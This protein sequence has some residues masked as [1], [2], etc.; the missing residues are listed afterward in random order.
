MTSRIESSATETQQHTARSGRNRLARLVDKV[1]LVRVL[2]AHDGLSARVAQMAGYDAVWA[3]GLGVSASHGLPDR[4]GITISEMARITMVMRRAS[5][6][7]I[8]VD[9]DAGFADPY[10]MQRMVLE[11]AEAGATAVCIED[12]Q[13]PKVNSFRPGNRLLAPEEFAERIK[14]ATD[15]DR[16]GLAIIARIESFIA[17]E[18]LDAAINRAQIYAKAGADALLI[19]SKSDKPREVMEFCRLA[20]QEGIDLPLCVV[21]TTYPSATA[22]ELAATGVDL[23]V[24]ANQALRAALSAMLDVAR[25]IRATDRSATIEDRVAS[26]ADVFTATEPLSR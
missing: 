5:G 10:L 19:H 11:Y 20:R 12:K 1:G 6:M 9:G 21:P 14:I 15:T 22:S 24:F 18:G 26:V 3:S 17:E 7:P 23:I 4:G 2:G 13:N 16:S 8:I 25:E